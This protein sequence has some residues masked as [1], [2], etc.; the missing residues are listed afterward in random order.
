MVRGS[1]KFVPNEPWCD[2]VF[3]RI[4]QRDK[5]NQYYIDSLVLVWC[6][7]SGLYSRL[8]RVPKS[9]KGHQVYTLSDT[10]SIMLLHYQPM[11]TC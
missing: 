4:L 9:G 1:G 8:M 7:C 5:V 3:S 10:K 6:S 2:Y 11:T